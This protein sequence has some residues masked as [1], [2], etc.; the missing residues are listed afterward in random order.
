VA[1]IS[2]KKLCRGHALRGMNPG[3]RHLPWLHPW[4]EGDQVGRPNHVVDSGLVLVGKYRTLMLVLN[5]LN[6]IF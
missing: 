3:H 6:F 5:L 4:G 1:T 2:Y